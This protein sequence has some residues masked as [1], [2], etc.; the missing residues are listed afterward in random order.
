MHIIISVTPIWLTG[1]ELSSDDDDLPH[2]SNDPPVDDPMPKT[3]P[4]DVQ[5]PKSQQPPP[6][7]DFSDFMRRSGGSTTCM[8][9]VMLEVDPHLPSGPMVVYSERAGGAMR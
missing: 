1:Y 5:P 2:G 4:P 8:F 3:G 7:F 9:F 6:T